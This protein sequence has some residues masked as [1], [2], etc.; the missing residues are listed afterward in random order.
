ML[1]D[2]RGVRGVSLL[3]QNATTIAGPCQ[4]NPGGSRCHFLSGQNQN[5]SLCIPVPECQT[6]RSVFDRKNHSV[7][8]TTDTKETVEVTR[9]TAAYTL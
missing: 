4:S 8:R 9:G 7:K 1:V 5:V 2:G 6:C 3:P